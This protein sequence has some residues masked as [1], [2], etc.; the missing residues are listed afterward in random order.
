[1]LKRGYSTAL[2]RP[3]FSILNPEL[4]YTVNPTR[5]PAVLSTSDAHTGTLPPPHHR[6]RPDRPFGG[7]AVKSTLRPAARRCANPKDY[8]A[9]AT[10]MWAGTFPITT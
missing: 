9:R 6:H 5:P 2:N 10:L 3:L 4:T 1:M 7:G 8:E